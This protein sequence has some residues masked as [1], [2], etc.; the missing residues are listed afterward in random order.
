MGN[1]VEV[2]IGT[3]TS[4]KNRIHIVLRTLE[5]DLFAYHEELQ[6]Q[7]Q[8]QTL[9]KAEGKSRKNRTGI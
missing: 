2:E 3:D 7:R 4:H 9:R 1:T 8:D 6:P 5:V